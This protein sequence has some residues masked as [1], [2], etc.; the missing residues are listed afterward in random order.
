MAKRFKLKL[1]SILICKSKNPSNFPITPIPL[2]H[3]PNSTPVHVSSPPVSFGCGGN[4]SSKKPKKTYIRYYSNITDS[5]PNT[6]PRKKIYN[7]SASEGSDEYVSSSPAF[8]KNK[9]SKKPITRFSNCSAE[10][11]W[12]SSEEVSRTLS[13]NSSSSSSFS[14]SGTGVQLDPI[15]ETPING[16]IVKRKPKK[17]KSGRVKKVKYYPCRN[18]VVPTGKK[19]EAGMKMEESLAVMK[20]SEDPY[21][22]FR[23]SMMEMIVE[24]EM[25]ETKDL[26]QLLQCFLSLNSRHHYGVII[27]AFSDIWEILFCKSAAM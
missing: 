8:E 25:F 21:G 3:K 20:K 22:D 5:T 2:S 10:T 24:R 4:R 12:F 19:E 6:P 1:S 23:R 13:T 27:Q 16:L 9:K 11:A 7:S 18:K 14:D 26:E 17:K 15:N